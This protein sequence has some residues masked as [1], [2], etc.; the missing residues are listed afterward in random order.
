MFDPDSLPAAKEGLIDMDTLI[1]D[2][3]PEH[4]ER[5]GEQNSRIFSVK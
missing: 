1:I 4:P 3:N 5:E 2:A